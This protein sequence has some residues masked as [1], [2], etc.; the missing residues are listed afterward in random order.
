MVS[1]CVTVLTG[2]DLQRFWKIEDFN[3]QSSPL[4]ADER[5]VVEH[6]YSSY[7]GDEA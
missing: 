6:F 3:Y 5:V 4:S 7:N 1:F 2:D